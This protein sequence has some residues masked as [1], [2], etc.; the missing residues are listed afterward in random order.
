MPVIL[1]MKI[2]GAANVNMKVLRNNPKVINKIVWNKTKEQSFQC[3]TGSDEIQDLLRKATD[4]II[5]DAD[6]A[7]DSFVGCLKAASECMLKQNVLMVSGLNKKKAEWFDEEC[8]EHKNYVK[9]L[10]KQYKK[11]RS[12]E[13][14]QPYTNA[15][16]VYRNLITQKKNQYCKRKAVSLAAS[17]NNSFDFWKEV[18]ARCGERK[19]GLS[20]KNLKDMDGLI[21]SNNCFP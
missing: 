15:N 1:K 5:L 13:S 12:E 19:P 20:E 11:K 9:R 10:L 2:S 3:C 6:E 16:K 18:R 17:I 7:L 8:K 14:R 21:T 4:E